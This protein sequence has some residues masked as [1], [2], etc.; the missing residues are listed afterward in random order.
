MNPWLNPSLTAMERNDDLLRNIYQ[1]EIAEDQ[2]DWWLGASDWGF[3]IDF[4][5][6]SVREARDQRSFGR[7]K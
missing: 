5:L 6:V 3:P 4:L 1:E 2:T 7:E